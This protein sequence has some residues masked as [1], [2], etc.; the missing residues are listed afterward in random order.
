MSNIWWGRRKF[1]NQD[2]FF[3][4]KW[5]SA[6]LLDF[7]IGFKK[8]C[9][10]KGWN[11][12]KPHFVEYSH[13]ASSPLSLDLI[14]TK[15]RLQNVPKGRIPLKRQSRLHIPIPD[16]F[17]AINITR[18]PDLENETFCG[19]F[20]INFPFTWIFYTKFGCSEIHNRLRIW[21]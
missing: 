11:G 7:T 16:S 12:H 10:I 20:R 18:S 9:H 13:K 21:L 17:S 8:N 19:P 1:S 14:L 6:M 2:F 15:G 3:M 4:W 5:A